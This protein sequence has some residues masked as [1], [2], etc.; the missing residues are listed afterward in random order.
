MKGAFIVNLGDM[1]ER[2]TNGM[3]LSTRHRVINVA[4]R[5]RLSMPFFFGA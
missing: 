4:G 1:L 2:W 3:F 5:Q